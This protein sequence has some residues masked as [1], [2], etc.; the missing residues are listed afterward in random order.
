MTN[1]LTIILGRGQAH[2]DIALTDEAVSRRHLALT[3]Y[4]T[5]QIEIS[6]LG[7]THGSFYWNGES[8]QAFTKVNLSAND[9]IYIGNAK[10]RVMEILIAYQIKKRNESYS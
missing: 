5:E 4:S 9:Y 8:W 6:D 3:C 2:C 1:E 7:S 10:L